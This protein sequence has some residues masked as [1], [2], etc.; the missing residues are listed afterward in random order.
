MIGSRL[1]ASVALTAA[2][3]LCLGMPAALRAASADPAAAAG[4][5]E[6]KIDNFTF[7]PASLKVAVG[8]PVTWINYDD[9]P[10]TVV[11]TDKTFKSKTLD[12][13]DKFSFTFTKAGKYPY[14]C[15]LHPRMT[16]EVVVQ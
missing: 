8:S 1:F 12:T 6:I 5:V 3:A 16:G 14:F 13:G 7:A 15:S 9:I 11:S 10:H 4:P 2:L